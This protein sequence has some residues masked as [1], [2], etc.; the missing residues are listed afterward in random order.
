MKYLSAYEYTYHGIEHEQ[1]FQGAGTEGCDHVVTGTGDTLR[2]AMEDALEQFSC[3]TKGAPLASMERIVK[4]LM[5]PFSK[6]DLDRSCHAAHP[7]C[8]SWATHGEEC[9]WEALQATANTGK[10]DV[11]NPSERHR[12]RA[13]AYQ[14]DHCSRGPSGD[15]CENCDAHHYVSLRW[16]VEDVPLRLLNADRDD[17]MVLVLTPQGPEYEEAAE[18][19]QTLEGSTWED[20]GDDSPYNL[21]TDRVNLVEDLRKEGYVLN[22][23]EYVPPEEH[24]IPCAGEK[25]HTVMLAD[26][27][28]DDQL[29]GLVCGRCADHASGDDATKPGEM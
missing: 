9:W 23:S 26:A 15:A 16:S 25:S 29:G 4:A 21:I 7:A 19:D 12:I 14:K 3:D 10:Y 1:Y 13:K 22:L 8:E 24:E 6:A 18:D 5:A 20:S 2:L 27:H 28:W 11:N 17:G